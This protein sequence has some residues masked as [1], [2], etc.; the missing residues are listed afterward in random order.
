[1]LRLAHM[2][3][4][5]ST[6]AAIPERTRSAV[7][8]KRWGIGLLAVCLLAIGAY[9]FFTK[10]G[11][12]QPRPAKGSPGPARAVP[13]V[14]V[15]AKTGD[16]GVYLTGLGSVT[17]LKTVTVK[18]RVD[19]ELMAVLYQ[20]GQIVRTGDLLAQ[21]DPRPFETQLTQAEGQLVRDQALLKNAQIDLARYRDLIKQD[22]IP[23]QQL[24]TQ[25]YLVRQYEG[26]IKSDQGQ[27][28]N[29]KLQLIYCRITAPVSGR[30]GLRL[31]DPG[32]IVHATDPNG[33]V[34]IT[35]LQPITVVFTIPED[36][37]PPVLAKLKAG[38]RLPV[39]AFDREQKRRLATGSLLTV[40]NQIDPNTGTVKLKAILPNED[41]ELFPNQFVNARLRLDVK[42]GSTIVPT[43]A[44]QRGPQ[45]VVFVYVVKADQTVAVRPVTVGVTQGDEASIETGLSPDEV[46]VVDGTEKLREGSAVDVKTRT[47]TQ[48]GETPK[49]R[50]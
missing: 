44:I 42:H 6:K 24:D 33:L 50:P 9:V 35:Q 4:Q 37:L 34:V 41:N 49:R 11:E 47:Q 3:M 22:L 13:V 8:L 26:T 40:D 43:A 17:P 45:G 5:E 7:L 46:V 48:T 29:V 14:A 38:E 23:Q 39:E 27:I 18:S 12:A 10:S 30:V 19:G 1:M 28:D 15:A 36:S 31:V 2:F 20:E 16:I 25:V 32:N 21:I